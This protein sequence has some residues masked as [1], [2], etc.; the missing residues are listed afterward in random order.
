ML[1]WDDGKSKLGKKME[2]F[3]N[4]ARAAGGGNLPSLPRRPADSQPARRRS[5]TPTDGPQK[6]GPELP[7]PQISGTA[8][9]AAHPQRTATLRSV[10]EVC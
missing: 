10:F 5:P 8:E 7:C 2:K 4:E 6:R 9:F 1:G 3:L